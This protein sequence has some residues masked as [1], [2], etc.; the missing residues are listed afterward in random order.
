MKTGL[1]KHIAG[2]HRMAAGAHETAL[3]HYQKP[4]L[5]SRISG[6]AK[7]VAGEKAVFFVYSGDLSVSADLSNELSYLYPK[8][9]IVVA[10]KNG[11]VTNLSLRGKNVRELLEK[12]LKKFENATGGGHEDAVGARI[13]TEDLDRFKELLIE[14]VKK[15]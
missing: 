2:I 8:R 12:L 13:K 4:G 7:K 5:L 9:Y 15:K 6:A 10:Y 3:K 1:P 11:S 14:E